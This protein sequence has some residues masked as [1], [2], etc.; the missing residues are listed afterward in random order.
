M[1]I[2][3]HVRPSVGFVTEPP[4]SRTI[5]G[6]R[7][8]STRY[9]C[10]NNATF[11]PAWLFLPPKL[12]TTGTT[13]PPAPDPPP[14][15]AVAAPVGTTTSMRVR[16]TNWPASLPANRTSAGTPPIVTPT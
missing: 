13:I 14:T 5:L 7:H 4:P 11:T 1:R 8:R 9:C 10:C 2:Y 6:D 3:C 12:T 16:L 15:A